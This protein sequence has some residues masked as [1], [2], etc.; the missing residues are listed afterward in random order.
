MS[1]MQLDLQAHEAAIERFEIGPTG[2]A[3]WLEQWRGLQSD[4]WE[5]A[6]VLASDES[7]A[8]GMACREWSL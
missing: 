7:H 6:V 8:I 2:F 3:S 5:V 4:G 1:Q